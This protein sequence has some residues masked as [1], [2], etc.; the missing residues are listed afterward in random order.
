MPGHIKLGKGNEPDPDPAPYLIVSMEMKRVDMLKSYDSKKSY[1]V[2][3]GKGGFVQG[4]LESNAGGK[5]VV[6][7][8]HEVSVQSDIIRCK[9]NIKINT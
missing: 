9:L 8:G 7:V 5:A 2:Q 1:W 3:D 6:M 4:M